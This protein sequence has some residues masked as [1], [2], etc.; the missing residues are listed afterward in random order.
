MSD[1][2]TIAWVR[3]YTRQVPVTVSYEA[4]NGKP[5]VY[6]VFCG[7]DDVTGNI[8]PAEYDIIYSKLT[9]ELNQ[10]QFEAAEIEAEGE[11]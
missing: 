5:I 6:G 1:F 10:T 8:S 11:R 2:Q 3:G 9:T 7:E 4:D